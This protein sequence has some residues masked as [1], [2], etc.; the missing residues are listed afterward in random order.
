MHASSHTWRFRMRGFSLVGMKVRVK[1]GWRD[2][3]WA[4]VWPWLE[5][6]NLCGGS[7][8]VG[9]LVPG[10]MRALPP[11]LAVN[12]PIVLNRLS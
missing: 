10:R 3:G 8:V 5:G 12:T 6:F 11:P 7:F 1:T 2:D 9:L 4:F